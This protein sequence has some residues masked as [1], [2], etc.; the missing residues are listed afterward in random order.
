MLGKF[1]KTISCRH[2]YGKTNQSLGVVVVLCSKPLLMDA[3]LVE[4]VKEP[5]L[6]NVISSPLW[7]MMADG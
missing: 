4:V 6:Q 5:S 7:L 1:V 3:A 2:F